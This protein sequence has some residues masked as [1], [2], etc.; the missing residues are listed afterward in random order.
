M[1]TR[2]F[3]SNS[4]SIYSVIDRG[5]FVGRVTPSSAVIKA[6]LVREGMA[7]RLVAS[8]S[9]SLTTPIYS[10]SSARRRTMETSSEF[11]LGNLEPD[12]HYYYAL[13]T[14]GRL[15]RKKAG[16][17]RTFPTPGRRRSPLRSRRARRLVRPAMCLIGFRENHPLFYMNMAISIT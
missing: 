13:E 16:E 4:A 6:K 7:A 15:D 17:F 14:D 8:T 12:T 11:S 3:S 1:F 10:A 9:P 5:P 2:F